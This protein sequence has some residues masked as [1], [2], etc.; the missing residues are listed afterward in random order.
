LWRTHDERRDYT[1]STISFE[2]SSDLREVI[3]IVNFGHAVRRLEIDQKIPNLEGDAEE[4]CDYN[5]VLMVE[6][7][8]GTSA[9]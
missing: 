5:L 4:S 8:I 6:Y 3:V 1:S 2:I 7:S 9:C